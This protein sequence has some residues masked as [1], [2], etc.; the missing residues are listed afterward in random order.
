MQRINFTINLSR[1]E[2]A[3]MFFINEEANETVLAFSN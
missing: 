1:T 3:K 2:A